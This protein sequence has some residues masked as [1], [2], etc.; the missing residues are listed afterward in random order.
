M[1]LS[2]IHKSQPKA[3]KKLVWDADEHQGR[4]GPHGTAAPDSKPYQWPRHIYNGATGHAEH[5]LK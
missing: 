4:E 5:I 2:T 1:K 3:R